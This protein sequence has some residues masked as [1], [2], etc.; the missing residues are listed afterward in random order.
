[1]KRNNEILKPYIGKTIKDI[2][3]VNNDHW[4]DPDAFLIEFTDGTIVEITADM[5]QG[6]G[7][8]MVN[9]FIEDDEKAHE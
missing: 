7:Y 9:E 3:D 2:I 1:M 8:V 6:A 4:S 5:G